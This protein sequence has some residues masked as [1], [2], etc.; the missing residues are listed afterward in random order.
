MPKAVGR[1]KV[2]SNTPGSRFQEGVVR[3]DRAGYRV[4]ADT[5]PEGS[6]RQARASVVAL[7]WYVT[8]LDE[9]THEPLLREDDSGEAVTEEL[10]FG[11][12]GKS[13]NFCH[14]GKGDSPDDDDPEDLGTDGGAEGNTLWLPESGR[15]KIHEMSGYFRLC[16]S[17]EK[18]GFKPEILDRMWA[19][20]FVGGIYHM[21]TWLDEKNKIKGEDGI[22]RPIPYKIVDKCI[23]H[24]YEGKGKG[25]AAGKGAAD[26]NSKAAG[27]DP[28]KILAGMMEQLSEALDGQTVSRKALGTRLSTMF[29]EAKHPPKLMIDV[30]SPA[31]DW[32]WLK[33]NGTRFDFRVNEENGEP[34]TVTFGGGPSY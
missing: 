7:M 26:G 19:P 16:E 32:E 25:K 23:K 3:I 27:S 18:V 4:N 15:L 13:L 2:A 33:K 24:G 34:V 8:R 29:Q 31:K 22:E 28:E 30:L 20:D 9:E 12:G 21:K 14:P 17:L 1:E 10:P 5:P 6:K 11:L